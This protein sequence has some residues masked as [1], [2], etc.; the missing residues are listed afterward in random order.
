MS[1]AFRFLL[2]AWLALQQG[3][4]SAADTAPPVTALANGL[5]PI[6]LTATPLP[7]WG[8][9]AR[10]ENFNAHGFDVLTL[11]IAA[12]EPS[13]WQIVPA[14]DEKGEHLT[15][16]ASG[17]ADC[18]LHD[19]RLLSPSAAGDALLILADRDLGDSFASPAPVQF[20][21][22]RLRQNAEGLPGRPAY[23]FEFDRAQRAT[24]PYCDVGD[25]LRS[26]LGVA[27]YR[28]VE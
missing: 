22:F 1:N 24:K 15:L 8:V 11:Y 27:A 9:L 21:F 7:A 23:Y 16:M 17:G 19:F 28:V 4:A 12:G 26:E 5:N 6:A 18:L 10:R 3:S 20:R 25:A 2:V 13:Q 14:F